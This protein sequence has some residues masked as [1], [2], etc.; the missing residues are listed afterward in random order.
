MPQEL[1][2]K[3]VIQRELPTKTISCWGE[4]DAKAIIGS[5]IEYT[6]D[7]FRWKSTVVKHPAIEVRVVSAEQFEREN[8]SP[9]VNDS[10]V[11]FR[12]LGINASDA[13]QVSIT[14]QPAEI[15][16]ATTEIPGD[17]VL[18]KNR[19]TIVFSVCNLYFEAKRLSPSDAEIRAAI[20]KLGENTDEKGFTQF[21][22]LYENPRRSTELL[23]ATLKPVRR[24]QYV[25]GRHPQVVWNIRALRSLTGLDFRAPTHADLT[26]DEAHFLDH[27]PKTEEVQFFGT[28]MS[29]D[30]VWVAPLD[31]QTTIIKKWRTWFREHGQLFTYVN[32]RNFDDW[33]F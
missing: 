30:R 17:E 7:S 13:K 3:W 5:E 31:A 33:Y 22:I 19:D 20:A 25:S 6:P 18:L 14:H 8:S 16:K 21:E 4:E 1:V 11:S 2:G 23:V 10:Q 32:D 15:T 28:W 24:G 12:Q 29:R 9:S 27:N 26:A